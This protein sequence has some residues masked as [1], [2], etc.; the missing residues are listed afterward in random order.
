MSQDDCL[1]NLPIAEQLIRV[2]R[3]WK[4]VADREL[5]PLELTYPRW[6][7]LWKLH[8]MGDNI[9]QKSL[10]EG[11]E[12]ELASLMRTLGQLEDQDL[13]I[14]QSS[15]RDK[16]VRIV[17]L[18]EA[19]RQLIAQIEAHILHVRRTLL[20]SLSHQDLE[21]FSMMLGQIAQNALH[22]LNS[23]NPLSHPKTEI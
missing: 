8:L 5:A 3:L 19:G 13:V 7:A 4:M 16:R 10:A 9:S 22:L 2:S 20:A 14:R 1:Q 6:T 18:T 11:L 21:Q 15:T 17:S 23:D 12:I